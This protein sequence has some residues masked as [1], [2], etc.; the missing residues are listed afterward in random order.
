MATAEIS[1][2]IAAHSCARRTVR[3][4][5][6][7]AHFYGKLVVGIKNGDRI[8]QWLALSQSVQQARLRPTY[9]AGTERQG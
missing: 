9:Q 7:R 8:E 4:Q 2:A 1:S 5:K 6:V 3:L